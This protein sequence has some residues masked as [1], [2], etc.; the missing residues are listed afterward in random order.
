[1]SDRQGWRAH[2][3]PAP[4]L[5]GRAASDRAWG[6]GRALIEIRTFVRETLMATPLR[7]ERPDAWRHFVVRGERI[8]QGA[9][10][11]RI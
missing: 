7:I 5:W 9:C 6:P 8:W 1:M 2:R 3:G 10:F 11:H 4:V